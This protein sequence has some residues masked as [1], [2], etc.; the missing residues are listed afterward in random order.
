LLCTVA[1]VVFATEIA[2]KND[3]NEESR[4]VDHRPFWAFFVFIFFQ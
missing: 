4:N 2:H 1:L 3:V